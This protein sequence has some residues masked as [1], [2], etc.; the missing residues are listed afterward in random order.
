MKTRNKILVGLGVLLL[1]GGIAYAAKRAA[2]SPS[3]RKQAVLAVVDRQEIMTTDIEGLVA[4][5]MS[6]PVA[7]EAAITREIT[8]EA[9]RSQWPEETRIIADVVLREALSNYYV[10]RKHAELQKAVKDDDVSRYYETNMRDEMYSGQI[11]K[12]YL[13]QDAKDAGEMAEAIRKNQDALLGRFSWVNKAGDHAVMPLAVPYGL[14]QQVKAMQPGQYAGPFSVRDGLLF[15]KLDDR[16]PGQRPE[17]AKVR[18]DIQV[19]IAQQRLEENVKE[20]RT[21]AAIQLK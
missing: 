15:L 20:L 11:L 17:L 14:Y 10:R 13:T 5:G 1:V 6:K 19:V 2:S 3:E 12:Y 21:K 4:S 9:A 7:L 8:A 16:K 18:E